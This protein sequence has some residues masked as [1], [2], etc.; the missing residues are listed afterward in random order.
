M[1]AVLIVVVLLV[2][3]AMLS[4]KSGRPRPPPSRF[5]LFWSRGDYLELPKRWVKRR[6]NDRRKPQGD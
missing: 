5:H 1:G 6:G 4:R 2:I 3:I